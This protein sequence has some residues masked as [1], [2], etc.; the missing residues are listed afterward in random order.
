M[1]K[2]YLLISL[3][4]V[5]AF[6]SSAKAQS[7]PGYSEPW[8]SGPLECPE[9]MQ[10]RFAD[11]SF[12]M[13]K[14]STA[15]T[16]KTKLGEYCVRNQYRQLS[17]INY[18]GT[19]GGGLL[20][21]CPAGYQKAIVPSNDYVKQS[22]CSSGEIFDEDFLCCPSERPFYIDPPN[23]V[24]DLLEPARCFSQAELSS[25]CLQNTPPNGIGVDPYQMSTGVVP[26]PDIDFNVLP[27]GCLL[28]D[29]IDTRCFDL[30]L[31]LNI[32]FSESNPY[33]TKPTTQT[34]ICGNNNCA[35]N[36]GSMPLPDMYN[37]PLTSEEIISGGVNCI[38]GSTVGSGGKTSISQYL[39]NES[40]TRSDE[41]DKCVCLNGQGISEYYL[42]LAGETGA[43]ILASCS[44]LPSNQVDACTKC[45]IQN[46]QGSASTSSYNW[47][48]SLGCIDTRM[49]PFITRL[50]Q[51]G[52]GIG[53]GLAVIRIIQGAFMR[54]T[55]DPAK[56][57]EGNEI[58]TSTVLGLVVLA[59][60]MVLLQI[61]GVNVLG[62]F[63]Y[64]EYISIVGS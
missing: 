47:S 31:N 45:I 58:I 19:S 6:I 8:T 25:I 62:L 17:I 10:T 13:N 16:L 60:A 52:L 38:A 23:L 20:Y 46:W 53:S 51:I 18:L 9:D 15:T 54:Q 42:S 44:R 2:R 32:F 5:L 3:V 57:Q 61:I 12:N 50:I 29:F 11:L 59:A 63:T 64:Q 40:C 4:T 37:T 43:E 48:A 14:E 28:T 1:I 7:V 34:W 41:N 30:D 49:N 22:G 27:A 56:I 35:V 36:S 39:S 33:F 55:N 26:N 21:M 24:T